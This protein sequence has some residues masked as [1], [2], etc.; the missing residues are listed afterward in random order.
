MTT[1]EGSG[2]AGKVMTKPTLS[3]SDYSM[4]VESL[5]LDVGEVK[6][7]PGME[8]MAKSMLHPSMADSVSVTYNKHMDDNNLRLIKFKNPQGQVEYHIHNTTMMPGLK[9]DNVSKLGFMSIAKMIHQD[10]L[11]EIEK[12]NT[13]RFQ[14]V[15]GSHQHAKY[16]SIIERIAKTAGKT[17]KHAGLLPI[18]S[19][20]FLRGETM[21]IECVI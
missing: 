19:A 3:F 18:T 6:N 2:Y 13:L 21:L 1:N 4:L 8:R 10:G 17:V 9:S 15:E 5:D 12:G 11:K 16:K 20:P 14:S 7:D